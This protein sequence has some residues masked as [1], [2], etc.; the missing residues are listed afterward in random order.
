M[1]EERIQK[2]I[3]RAGIASR[4]RAEE[5]MK[6]GLIT[7]NG[8]VVTEL[9]TKADPDRDDIR[10]EGE[11]L[12][13]PK[14]KV[15]VALNKPRGYVT[16]LSD[17][18]G[19]PTV[20]DL[21]SGLPR[22]FPVGR[23]DYDTEGLIICTSDGDLAQLLLHPKYEVPKVY[24]AKVRGTPSPHKLE[25]LLRGVHIG[26]GKPAK[27]KEARLVKEAEDSIVDLT[28]TE[29]RHHQVKRMMLAVGHPVRKLTRMAVGPLKLGTLK[30]GKWR[31]LTPQE[32]EKLSAAASRGPEG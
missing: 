15:Y 21:L 17:P 4:R 19:R 32:V 8:K 23:L 13:F 18:Q 10:L 24:R 25:R 12:R 3:A 22:V 27:A 31:P 7:V 11:R 29:G 16:T 5:L 20:A 2:I 30:S 14:E 28:I 6:L 26:P 1:A 9:G